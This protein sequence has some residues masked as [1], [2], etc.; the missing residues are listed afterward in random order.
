LNEKRLYF[1]RKRN[2]F[3]SK[4]R[5]S[6]REH[7]KKKIE[8]IAKTNNDEMKKDERKSKYEKKEKNIKKT[9]RRTSSKGT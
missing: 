9:K 4:C 5:N 3:E 6:K 1:E 2:N 7:E 8:K